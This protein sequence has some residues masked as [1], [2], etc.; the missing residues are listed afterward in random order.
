MYLIGA[1]HPHKTEAQMLVERALASQDRLITDA[2]VLQEIVHRYASIGRREGIADAFG[3][4]LVLS[5]K[6]SRSKVGTCCG[7]ARSRGCRNGGPRAT[8]FISPSW[9]AMESAAS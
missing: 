9:S 5:M 1:A 3:S 6:C 2:E 7:P 8:P 4:C